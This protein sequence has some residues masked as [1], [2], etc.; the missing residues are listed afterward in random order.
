MELLN[1][2]QIIQNLNSKE[3]LTDLVNFDSKYYECIRLLPDVGLVMH[4]H[5]IKE[6]KSKTRLSNQTSQYLFNRVNYNNRSFNKRESVNQN[7]SNANAEN[8]GANAKKKTLSLYE[9]LRPVLSSIEISKFNTHQVEFDFSLKGVL[10]ESSLY[11]CVYDDIPFNLFN[12]QSKNYSD[13]FRKIQN[14]FF[15]NVDE[16]FRKLDE[17]KDQS[18][19]K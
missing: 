7:L 8:E 6:A 14:Y 15:Q 5:A 10:F 13:G 16:T 9:Q 18:V 2:E 12:L 17:Q 3:Q 1:L 4:K 19:Q 11:V